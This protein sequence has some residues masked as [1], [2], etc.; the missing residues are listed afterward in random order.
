MRTGITSPV[1]T[2]LND[3]PDWERD[4]RVGDIRRVRDG[5]RPVGL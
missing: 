4:A 3:P 1:V 5:R 2:Q